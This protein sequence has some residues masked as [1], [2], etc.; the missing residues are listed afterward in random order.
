MAVFCSAEVVD[1]GSVNP[2]YWPK[3]GHTGLW[4]K[5]R[6]RK[7]QFW[8]VLELDGYGNVFL[9]WTVMKTSSW[10]GRLRKRL[11]ELD[12]YENVVLNWTVKKTSSRTG[13]SMLVGAAFI[14]FYCPSCEFL[15]ISRNDDTTCSTRVPCVLLLSTDWAAR[16]STRGR[17]HALHSCRAGGIVVPWDPQGL[18][19]R[20][21]HTSVLT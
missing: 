19:T 21:V 7:T 4:K 10:T 5:C 18:V 9:S 13:R 2:F 6:L 1:K 3:Y 17:Q 12:G 8:M 20:S 16:D 14:A 11:L 15:R